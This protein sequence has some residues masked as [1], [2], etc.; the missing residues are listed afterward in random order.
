[1]TT[2]DRSIRESIDRVAEPDF[3]DIVSLNF[4]LVIQL[5]K[6]LTIFGK[7]TQSMSRERLIRVSNQP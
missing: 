3:P 1:V 2:T 7:L 5:F 6:K 4:F